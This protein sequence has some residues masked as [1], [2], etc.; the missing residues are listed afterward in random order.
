LIGFFGDHSHGAGPIP[1]R[2]PNAGRQLAVAGEKKPRPY[3]MKPST[4]KNA[5]R[6]Q[7]PDGVQFF[8]PQI[9]KTKGD[10][11]L[12]NGQLIPI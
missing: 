7:I 10:G 8:S 6:D 12:P 2:A 11:R 9:D 5:V 3:D 4:K 1:T